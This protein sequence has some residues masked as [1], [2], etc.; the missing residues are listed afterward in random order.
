MGRPVIAIVGVCAAGKSTL[1]RGLQELGY[2][3]Y[4]VP[5]EH[6][7]VRRLWAR[8]NPDLLIMLDA[9][10]ETTRRRRPDIGYGPERLAEQRERLR[11]ARA[12]CD[13]YLPTDDLSIAEVRQA[14]VALA[15]QWQERHGGARG[16]TS[17]EGG[18]APW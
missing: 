12:E 13:L 16:E 10:W 5:Q 9:Q 18:G 11:Y 14:A 2:E 15:R 7:V 6:S 8:K 1:A 17:G 3:A 4:S